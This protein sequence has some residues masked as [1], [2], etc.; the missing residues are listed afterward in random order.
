MLT[1][2]LELASQHLKAMQSDFLFS[3]RNLSDIISNSV[4]PT[5]AASTFRPYSSLTADA[6][7]VRVKTWKLKVILLLLPGVKFN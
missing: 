3:L 6:G 4:H 7:S 1:T 2:A 5:S